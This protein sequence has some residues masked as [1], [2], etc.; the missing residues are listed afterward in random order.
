MAH[1][2]HN[3]GKISM[4]H[5]LYEASGSATLAALLCLTV[6]HAHA[7]DYPPADHHGADVVLA[8]GDRIWG[9]H[10]NVG[11][12][13]ILVGSTATVRPYVPT[14]A[15]SGKL[16]LYAANVTIAGTLSADGSG[17]TGG[18][19]IGG[20]EGQSSSSAS[21][22]G[23]GRYGITRYGGYGATTG[24][25]GTARGQYVN[26]LRNGG[27][28][29]AGGNTDSSRDIQVL[30]GSG[31]AAGLPEPDAEP[32]NGPVCDA[33]I[34]GRDGGHGGCPGG[35]AIRLFARQTLTITGRVST[36]GAL[37]GRGLLGTQGTTDHSNPFIC[38][39]RGGAGGTGGSGDISP[40]TTWGTRQLRPPGYGAGG[41]ILLECGALNGMALGTA[42]IDARGSAWS[43]SADAPG[44]LAN[45]GTVKILYLG[46]S[47]PSTGAT[48]TG[49]HT[50][51]RDLAI[52]PLTAIDPI[53]GRTPSDP[54]YDSSGDYVLDA[55]DIVV[56]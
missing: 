8:N 31:G 20:H 48:I 34:R 15:E 26:G 35:G 46:A 12:F 7:A 36:R 1:D 53:L 28:N 2:I 41:G 24:G 55:A 6:S 19:G 27:Y 49:N 23:N 54:V 22:Y 33:D 16:D 29:I 4:I 43:N 44:A 38:V 50:M 13:S 5:R 47:D 10:L 45:A 37:G 18:G 56:E 30:M 32:A 9:R 17:F 39:A 40:E 42:T 25:D 3:D 52:E 11:S 14:V 21:G 51:K